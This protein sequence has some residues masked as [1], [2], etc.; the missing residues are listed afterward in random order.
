V[1]TLTIILSVSG[2]LAAAILAYLVVHARRVFQAAVERAVVARTASTDAALLDEHARAEH[3]KQRAA[4]NFQ[5][6]VDME[7]ERDEW[8]HLCRR[9][10][11]A[12]S[13]AQAWL[14][15]EL[16]RMHA[17]AAAYAHKVGAEPPQ[18]D[19]GLI[20]VVE[21]FRDLYSKPETPANHPPGPG[22]AR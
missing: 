8:R 19:P 1:N 20:P 5:L 6:I 21:E 11:A 16:Q 4:Q 12:H 22:A 15:R 18:I 9:E 10:G 2:G 3:N 13:N 14:L 7:R 17:V